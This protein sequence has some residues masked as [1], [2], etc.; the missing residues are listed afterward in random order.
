MHSVST[1]IEFG[2]GRL[3][4]LVNQYE[5]YSAMI[6]ANYNETEW[7]ALHW[8]ARARAIAHYRLTSHVELHKAEAAQS[9]RQDAE[10]ARMWDK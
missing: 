4:Y 5:E 1:G 2:P 6:H 7:K 3:P 8:R 10:L 9:S